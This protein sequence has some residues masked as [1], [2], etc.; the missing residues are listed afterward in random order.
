MMV[1]QNFIIIVYLCVEA[2]NKL[3]SVYQHKPRSIETLHIP[4]V[5]IAQNK[6]L[7]EVPIVGYTSVPTI[8]IPTVRRQQI[9]SFQS[10]T[11][12]K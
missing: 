12:V 10:V 11:L 1:Q 4:P 2:L 6:Q 7:T 5:D 8:N 3:P 9:F